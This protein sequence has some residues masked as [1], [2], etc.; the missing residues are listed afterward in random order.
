MKQK[1]DEDIEIMKHH[2]EHMLSMRF[3]LSLLDRMENAIKFLLIVLLGILFF[4]SLISLLV[5][6]I[7]NPISLWLIG[8]T[9]VAVTFLRRIIK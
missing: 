9:I 1:K 2:L 4:A 7:K 3:K 5:L 8:F 6:L